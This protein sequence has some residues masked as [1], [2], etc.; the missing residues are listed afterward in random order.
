MAETFGLLGYQK[1]GAARACS[2]CQVFNLLYT[3]TSYSPTRQPCNQMI[4]PINAVSTVVTAANDS[5]I[6]ATAS[7]SHL[8]QHKRLIC[9]DGI[10]ASAKT[11]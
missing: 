1:F 9:R 6:Q 5:Y 10:N 3:A 11:H 8:R 4:M 2:M 7:A